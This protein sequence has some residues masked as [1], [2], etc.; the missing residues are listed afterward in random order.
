MSES[1]AQTWDEIQKDE[2]GKGEP[3]EINFLKNRFIYNDATLLSKLS[4]LPT[5][6]YKLFSYLLSAS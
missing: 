6:T 1:K 2:Y 4:W 5:L 3:G